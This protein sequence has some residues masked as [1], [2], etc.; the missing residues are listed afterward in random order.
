[1]NRA[2]R[3]LVLIL[4]PAAALLPGCGP[5]AAPVQPSKADPAGE[6][7]YAETAE[8][9]T[10]MDRAA[11][12]LFQS[13]RSQ[14]AAAIVTSGQSL[15]TRLLTAPRPTLAAMEAVADLDQVYGQMLIS[16]GYY[17]S[18]RLLFQKNVTRWKTW[19]PAAPETEQRLKQ[20]QAAISECDRHMG[21]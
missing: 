14:E 2:H 11:E 21:G 18:A 10:R 19:K 3:I 12:Q 4:V 6:A 13:G 9:L 5:A 15:Q 7:W 8:R 20:A 16:N 1:M 17:G